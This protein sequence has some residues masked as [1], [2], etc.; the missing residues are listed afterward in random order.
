MARVEAKLD[1]FKD[2]LTANNQALVDQIKAL[3]GQQPQ[4]LVAPA[5]PAPV[6]VQVLEEIAEIPEGKLLLSAF[7][8]LYSYQKRQKS[9]QSVEMTV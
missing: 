2:T 5:P 8:L 7:D 6:Q 9:A 1:A 3:F 4:A